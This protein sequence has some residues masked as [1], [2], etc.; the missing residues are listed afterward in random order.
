VP[1]QPGSGEN[2]RSADA[3]FFPRGAIAS[4]AAMVLFYAALWF[5]LFA[6]MAGRG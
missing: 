4:F 5:L 3:A 1:P 6:L 2:E